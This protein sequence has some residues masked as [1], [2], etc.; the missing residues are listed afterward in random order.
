VTALQELREQ[1]Q[2]IE[3]LGRGLNRRLYV[4]DWSYERIQEAESRL[5]TAG[6]ALPAITG[7]DLGLQRS[8]APSTPLSRTIDP[9]YPPYYEMVRTHGT[10]TDLWHEWSVRWAGQPSIQFLDDT[11]GHRWGR[12]NEV[13]FYSRR[14]LIIKE[15]RRLM[16]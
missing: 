4:N 8:A 3:S 10:V 16:E 9:A 11:W 6:L 14:R 15:I 13:F 5:E 1:R 7:S 12:G 2:L